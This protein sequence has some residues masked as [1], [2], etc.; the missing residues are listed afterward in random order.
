MPTSDAGATRCSARFDL[1]ISG[2]ALL[3][4]SPLSS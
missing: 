2:L 3:L 1:L 4:L